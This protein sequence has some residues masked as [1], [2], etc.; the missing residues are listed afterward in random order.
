VSDVKH[1]KG[2]AGGKAARGSDEL[3]PLPPFPE[4][5]TFDKFVDFARKIVNVPKSE[6]EEQE[7]LYQERRERERLKPP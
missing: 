3:P 4:T 5:P 6:I 1:A 7:R 2:A